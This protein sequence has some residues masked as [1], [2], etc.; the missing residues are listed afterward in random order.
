[1]ETVIR[2][3]RETNCLEEISIMY[4]RGLKMNILSR[5]SDPLHE[6]ETHTV[7]QLSNLANLP[8]LVKHGATMPEVHLGKGATV[9]PNNH[10]GLTAQTIRDSLR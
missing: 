6:V 8:F 5:F 7:V 2:I 1:M 4:Q 3:A 10:V 9:A